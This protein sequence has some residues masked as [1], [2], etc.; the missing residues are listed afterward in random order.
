MKY[1]IKEE[2]LADGRK[3]YHVQL[4]IHGTVWMHEKTCERFDEARAYVDEQVK[5]AED[6][7]VVSTKVVWESP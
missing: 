4:H 3:F 6:N 7:K 5:L 1:R 2:T